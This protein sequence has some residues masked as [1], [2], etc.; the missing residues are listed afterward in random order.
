MF[1]YIMTFE[2]DIIMK[3]IYEVE[4][5]EKKNYKKYIFSEEQK[6][7]V[8]KVLSAGARSYIIKPQKPNVLLQK[9]LS[10]LRGN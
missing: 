6:D 9:C 8:V 2:G 10:L 7:L 5:I 3:D 1:L 4:C